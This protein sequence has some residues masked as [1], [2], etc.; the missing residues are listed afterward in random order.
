MPI[1]PHALGADLEIS[2]GR[3]VASQAHHGVAVSIVDDRVECLRDQIQHCFRGRPR[4]REREREREE[5]EGTADV[6]AG[7]KPHQLQLIE[8]LRAHI[9]QLGA[10]NLERIRKHVGN[11][12]PSYCRGRRG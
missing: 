6:L 8:Q 5:V 7:L 3:L 11:L 1:E 12:A 9:K 4:E 2:G 10:L